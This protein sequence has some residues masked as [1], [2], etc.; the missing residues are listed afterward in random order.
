MN[1][2]KKKP[3]MKIYTYGDE[4]LKKKSTL[5]ESIDDEICATAKKMIESMKKADGVGLAAPQVGLNIQL[6][7]LEVPMPDLEK[8]P[9]TTPGEMFLIP[10]MPLCL[11][12]PKI[13]S[14]SKETTISEEGCLSIPKLYANVERSVKIELSAKMLNGESI[15]FE[16]GGFLARALQHEIDHLNGILFVDRLTKPEFNKIKFDLKKIIRQ[17][18]KKRFFKGRR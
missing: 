15:S 6:I 7:V 12:N 10:K 17:K 4:V 16:C 14:F 8:D 2:F 3:V 5:V 13:L 9:M 11:L 1:I 18:N